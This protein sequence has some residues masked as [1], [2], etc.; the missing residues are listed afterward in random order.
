VTG[1]ILAGGLS[2]RMGQDKAMVEIHGA[3]I[4]DRSV[5]LLQHLF[6]RVMV[7]TNSPALYAHLG[8]SLVGDLMPGRGALGGLHAALFLAPTPRIFVAA[9][10]MPFL[11]PA[12]IEW[13]ARCPSRWDVVVPKVRGYLEPLHAV[14]SRRCLKPVEEFLNTGGRKIVDFYPRVRVKEAPEEEFLPLDPEL[15]SFLN[16]NTPEDL[17]AIQG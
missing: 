8:V 16:I 3:R 12:V 17:S 15:R 5:A 7:V 10:D 13:L 4:I 1:V 14:Y 9:C 11:N 6:G 2:R